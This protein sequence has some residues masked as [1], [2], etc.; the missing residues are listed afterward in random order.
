MAHET[1]IEEDGSTGG[2]D[3][4][5]HHRPG[6]GKRA[7]GALLH[8]YGDYQL[9]SG[10]HGDAL[11]EILVAVLAYGNVVITGEQENFLVSL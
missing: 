1:S 4:D 5:F 10:A 9:L 8:H 2:S 7:A 11:V 6:S 3:I